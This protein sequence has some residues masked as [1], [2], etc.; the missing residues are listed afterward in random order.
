MIRART[1]I[2]AE[3]SVNKIIISTRE[4]NLRQK[5]KIVAAGVRERPGAAVL[6]RS[7]RGLGACG[8]MAGPGATVRGLGGRP[9][10]PPRRGG[11]EGLSPRDSADSTTRG[12]PVAA[13]TARGRPHPPSQT[14]GGGVSHDVTPLR[15]RNRITTKEL[16]TPSFQV[17]VSMRIPVQQKTRLFF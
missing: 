7:P 10:W 12:L 1:F 9:A 8:G 16:R 4:Q 14:G 13:W 15:K 6:G 2:S 3:V 11:R 17:W 5:Q